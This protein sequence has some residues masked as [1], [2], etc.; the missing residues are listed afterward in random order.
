MF[1][2]FLKNRALKPSGLRALVSGMEKMIALI[3]S[4]EMG[5]P[6]ADFA[7]SKMDFG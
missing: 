2:L 7:A 4:L 1:Q 3:S 6:K 5:W